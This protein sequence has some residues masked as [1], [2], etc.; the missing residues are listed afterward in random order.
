M[1]LRSYGLFSAKL[2][3]EIT[4]NDPVVEMDINELTPCLD[5][6]LWETGSPNQVWRGEVEDTEH[7]VDRIKVADTSYPI[8]ISENFDPNDDDIYI[9]GKYDCLDGLHRLCRLH[10]IEHRPTVTVRMVSWDQ[11]QRA[12][13]S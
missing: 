5:D 3:W 8:L 7:H 13:I 9:H 6:W 4:D 1:F 11:L 10:F 2:L 12:K